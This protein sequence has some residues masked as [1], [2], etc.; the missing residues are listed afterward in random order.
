MCRS[1]L[2]LNGHSED[3]CSSCAAVTVQVTLTFSRPPS[4]TPARLLCDQFH[5]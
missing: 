4:F 1:T 3:D 2:L 5:S